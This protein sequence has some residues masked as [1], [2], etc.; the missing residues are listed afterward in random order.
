MHLDFTQIA[1]IVSSSELNTHS[2]LEV[3]N[4]VDEWVNFDFDKRSEFAVSLLSKVRLD[5]LSDQA[6]NAV[7]NFDLAINKVNDCVLTIIDSLKNR[8]K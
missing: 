7:L 4:A 2:E 6:M 5:L 3:L 8:K 1:K